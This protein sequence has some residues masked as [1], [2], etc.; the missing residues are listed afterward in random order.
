MHRSDAGRWLDAYASAWE[1][2]DAPGAAALFTPDAVYRSHPLRDA[3]AGTDAIEEYWLGATSTQRDAR[4]VVGEPLVDGSRVVAEW[5]TT[6]ADEGDDVTLPGVLLLDFGDDGLCRRL[7]EYWAVGEGI[8]PPPEGWGRVPDADAAE[9]RAA[10][11]RWAQRYEAAWRALDAGAIAEL[12]SDDATYRS[13]PLR[14]PHLG[15][16]GV[17]EYTSE[18]LAAEESPDPRVAVV[19][20][21]GPCAAVEYRALTTQDGDTVTLTGC[22]VLIF[23]DD[24]LC[25]E[26]RDYRH[27]ERGVHDAR[28]EWGT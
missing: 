22:D 1:R 10:A 28:E 26:L 24:G 7:R 18:A 23:G 16:A 20:A 19:A 6:M 15:R 4:V 14:A 9:G 27:M 5:W 2:A 21:A 3:H 17:L 13:H 25:R 12:F 8:T 11:A